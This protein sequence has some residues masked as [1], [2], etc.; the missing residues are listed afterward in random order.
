MMDLGQNGGLVRIHRWIEEVK[1]TR[2]FLCSLIFCT[3]AS[4]LGCASK[5]VSNPGSSANYINSLR[6][7]INANYVRPP[8]VYTTGNCT[9]NLIQNETG[10]I[11]NINVECSDFSHDL[12]HAVRNAVYSAV[13]R[14]SP[15]P[16]PDDI[17]DFDEQVRLFVRY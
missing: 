5:P 9:V 4:L 10:E 3:V 15:L 14:S 1:F 8:G 17:N 6:A 11:E 12:T 13:Q 2:G 7:H 16:L